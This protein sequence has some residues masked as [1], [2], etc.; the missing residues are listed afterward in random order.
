MKKCKHNW[1][2][3]SSTVADPFP[4]LGLMARRECKNCGKLDFLN[5]ELEATDPVIEEDDE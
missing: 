2:Y 3:F 5:S 4:N 1:T